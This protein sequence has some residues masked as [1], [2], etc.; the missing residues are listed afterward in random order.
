M[1]LDDTNGTVEFQG[2]KYSYLAENFYKDIEAS[3][4]NY[5]TAIVTISR[6]G[7]EFV[8]NQSHDV[9]GHEDTTDH[10]LTLTDAEEAGQKYIRCLV[11]KPGHLLPPE[12][13]LK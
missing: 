13:S 11:K 2:H 6:T 7:S 5:G 4:K 1:T 8:D 10:Y 9:A 12:Y 3:Y